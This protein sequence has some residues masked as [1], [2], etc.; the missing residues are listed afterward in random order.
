[1][2]IRLFGGTFSRAAHPLFA[3]YQ[4]AASHTSTCLQLSLVRSFGTGTAQ[5]GARK[6]KEEEKENNNNNNMA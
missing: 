5:T 6:K 2:W 3:G 1:M 4:Q